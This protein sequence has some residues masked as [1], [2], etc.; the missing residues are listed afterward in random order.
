MD[1]AVDRWTTGYQPG[2]SRRCIAGVSRPRARIP[3]GYTGAS[4]SRWSK[5]FLLKR[6]FLL[7][8]SAGF[9]PTTF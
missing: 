6:R 4:E 7:A 3:L 8:R 2:V 1:G 9:E 5:D